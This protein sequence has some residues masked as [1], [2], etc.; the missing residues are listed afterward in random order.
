MKL[1]RYVVEYR[2]NGVR[3]SQWFRCMADDGPHAMEQAR[4]AYPYPQHR[5][6]SARRA[7]PIKREPL[8]TRTMSA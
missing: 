8:T 5:I 7:L 6:L 4:N 3:G 1:K 2:E